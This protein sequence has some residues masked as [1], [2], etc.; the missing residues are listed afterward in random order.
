M[1]FRH[2]AVADC[3]LT[4]LFALFWLYTGRRQQQDTERFGRPL[5]EMHAMTVLF[6]A[7]QAAEAIRDLKSGDHASGFA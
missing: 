5:F 4:T 2:F 3:I 1:A 7:P 6:E